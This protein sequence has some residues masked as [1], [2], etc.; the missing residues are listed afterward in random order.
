MKIPFTP[1]IY[2]HAAPICWSHSLGSLRDAELLFEGHRRAYLE[3]RQQVIAVAI[4]IY[5]LEA[6]AYGAKVAASTPDA[7]PAIHQPLL[8]SIEEGIHLPP[9]DPGRDGRIAMMLS[10]GR[11]LLCASFPRPTCVCPWAA[12]SRL[13]SICAA[14]TTFAWMPRSAPR[15]SPGC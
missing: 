10:V 9:F 8:S 6:E 15:N 13:P 7:I 5:N 3:Y 12:L 4:D 1:V 2:E 14:S 11:R